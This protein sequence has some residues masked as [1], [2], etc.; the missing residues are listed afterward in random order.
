MQD[1]RQI[2]IRIGRFKSVELQYTKIHLKPI[3]KLWEEFDSRQRAS[4]LA[5]EKHDADR[6]PSTAD[7]LS[8]VPYFSFSSWLPNF[9]DE[10]L[11]YLEQE[12]KWYDDYFSLFPFSIFISILISNY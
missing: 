2:L 6:L 10:V 5:S 1:L 9:F 7:S 11:L 12:W 3:R 4:K 8:N